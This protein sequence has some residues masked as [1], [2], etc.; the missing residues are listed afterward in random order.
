MVLKNKD[1]ELLENIEADLKQFLE[2]YKNGNLYNFENVL[3]ININARYL[4]GLIQRLKEN[5]EKHNKM[6][7]A[8]I[9]AKRQIDPKYA[10]KNCYYKKK[11]K[12]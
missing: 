7:Y 6:S 5:K 9:K 3:G 8:R 1:L 2:D 12:V 11:K 10:N 4:S